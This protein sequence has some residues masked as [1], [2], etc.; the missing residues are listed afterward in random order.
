VVRNVYRIL[1]GKPEGEETTQKTGIER[2]IIIKQKG[3]G[4]MDTIWFGKRLIVS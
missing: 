1:V 4:W 3:I 2:R